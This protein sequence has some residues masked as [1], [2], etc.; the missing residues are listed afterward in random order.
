MV[1]KKP[2]KNRDRQLE[3]VDLASGEIMPS[4]MLRRHKWKG[5]DFLM[6][7]QN[8]LGTIAKDKSISLEAK[9]VILY[10]LSKLDFENFIS[11]PHKK[12]AEE[13]NMQKPNVSRAMKLLVQ[14]QIVIEGPKENRSH[15]YRINNIYAWK[16]NLAKLKVVRREEE[17]QLSIC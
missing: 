7:F 10:L 2:N 1:S 15:T 14:K 5:E 4:I 12:I 17:K 9:N 16:G 3:I 11:L 6:I 8:A 13:L